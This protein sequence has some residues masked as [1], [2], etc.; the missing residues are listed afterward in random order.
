[1]FSLFTTFGKRSNFSSLNFA[2][3]DKAG[4]QAVVGNGLNE[5]DDGSARRL[6]AVLEAAAH[7]ADFLDAAAQTLVMAAES[8]LSVDAAFDVIKTKTEY[9]SSMR[10]FIL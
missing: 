5:V 3:S 8:D 1:M 9:N 10:L 6:S 7:C 4:Y 2:S